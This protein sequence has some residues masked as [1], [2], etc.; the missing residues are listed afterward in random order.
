MNNILIRIGIHDAA[1]DKVRILVYKYRKHGF[2]H[3]R[4]DPIITVYKRNKPSC[5]YRKTGIPGI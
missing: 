2:I 5:C 4:F 3:L 1:S